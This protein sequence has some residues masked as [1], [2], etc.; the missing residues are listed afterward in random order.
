MRGAPSVSARPLHPPPPPPLPPP[1][2]TATPSCSPKRLP[3]R[4]HLPRLAPRK[5]HHRNIAEVIKQRESAQ[6]ALQNGQKKRKKGKRLRNSPNN[7]L[8]E[9]KNSLR[10][11][12]EKKMED[13]SRPSTPQRSAPGDLARAIWEAAVKQLRRVWQGQAGAST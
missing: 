13:S 2:P 5:A 1:H 12:Q 9:I 11:V 8:K 6:R 4:L 10:S 7:I 3:P